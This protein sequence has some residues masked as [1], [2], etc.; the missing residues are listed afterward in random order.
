MS[1]LAE[2]S[3]SRLL[4]PPFLHPTVS[5]LR[6]FVPQHRSRIP[7]SSTVQTFQSNG[8]SPDAS[9]FSAISR[10][11]ST[12]NLNELQNGS[13]TRPPHISLGASYSYIP[14]SHPE[15]EV[16]R[17]TVLRHLS[18]QIYSSS[19]KAAAILDSHMGRPTALA[20]HGVVCIGTDTGRTFVFDFRQQLKC[21]CGSEATGKL[22]CVVYV[23]EKRNH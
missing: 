17:W 2:D 22:D 14:P 21:V 12:S 8:F 18:S 7:S 19:A 13:P 16:F 5:R 11:S 6:S 4:R 23:I 20:A 1:P 9:H 3:P 10:V 15:R